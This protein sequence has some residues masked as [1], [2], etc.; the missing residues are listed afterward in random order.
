MDIA[1]EV[2]YPLERIRARQICASAEGSGCHLLDALSQYPR[3]IR[4]GTDNAAALCAI[5]LKIQMAVMWCPVM[6]VYPVPL[7]RKATFRRMRVGI[8]PGRGATHR[9]I[10]LRFEYF[11]KDGCCF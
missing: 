8:G 2:S 7:V 9:A 4:D 10:V 1:E 3:L 5:I 11:C 6:R